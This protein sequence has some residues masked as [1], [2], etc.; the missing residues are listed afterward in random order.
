MAC[1][2]EVRVYDPMSSW[3][4]YI[5]ALNPEDED[6]ICCIIKGFFVEV[7]TWKLSELFQRFNVEGEC[8]VVD[9]E[10][11][12]RRAC[13]LFKILSENIYDARRN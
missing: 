1:L 11:R 2:A 12:P 10:Y 9:Y 5:Y 6:E 4:C 8:P 3:E 7:T 13:D